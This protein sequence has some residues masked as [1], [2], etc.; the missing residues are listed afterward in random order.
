MSLLGWGKPGFRSA[1]LPTDPRPHFPVRA[2]AWL[3]STLQLPLLASPALSS[4][5]FT[6]ILG[7]YQ[8]LFAPGSAPDLSGVSQGPSHSARG[9]VG[10]TEPWQPAPRGLLSWPGATAGKPGSHFGP[11]VSICK[12]SFLPILSICKGAC[13][14][15]LKCVQFSLLLWHRAGIN[16]SGRGLRGTSGPVPR[17][18]EPLNSH[19][20]M[21]YSPTYQAQGHAKWRH[22]E[23]HPTTPS[24][25]RLCGV[26]AYTTVH[27]PRSHFS[28][29]D[30]NKVGK[31]RGLA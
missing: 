12:M 24:S 15:S 22:T 3:V 21:K 23:T 31:M 28:P 13:R 4:R 2:H 1:P 7:S 26:G 10:G 6:L 19:F 27:A 5:I 11:G 9:R 17:E 29:D 16:T 8:A 14:N 25:W 18:L 30:G 20:L